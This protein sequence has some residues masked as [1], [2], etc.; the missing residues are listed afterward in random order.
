M[1]ARSCRNTFRDPARKASN[2]GA[3][4]YDQA[5]LLT[6]DG[7]EYVTNAGTMRRATR[8]YSAAA[9]SAS[10]VLTVQHLPHPTQERGGA[11]GG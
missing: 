1:S 7:A 8:S 9:L 6:C 2:L 10:L 11:P 3:E 4:R 5:I